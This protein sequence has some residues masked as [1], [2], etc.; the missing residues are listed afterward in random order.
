MKKGEVIK[1]MSRTDIIKRFYLLNSLK[2]S[3]SKEVD[4]L[5]EELCRIE[6]IEI[7]DFDVD[8]LINSNS[9]LSSNLSEEKRTLKKD[10]FEQEDHQS[11][12]KGH[13]YDEILPEVVRILRDSPIPVRASVLR[14]RLQESVSCVERHKN[15]TSLM[16]EVMKK[17]ERIIRP[18]RGFYE[19]NSN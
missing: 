7:G 8:I 6:G 1:M 19:Y 4:C 2:M 18:S 10:N 3:I 16:N 17:D 15:F 5:L 13:A 9:N 11:A 12:T 14:E